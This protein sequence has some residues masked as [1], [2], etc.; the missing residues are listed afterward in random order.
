MRQSSVFREAV[1]QCEEIV[2]TE[3]G[4]PLPITLDG[5]RAGLAAN[6][7]SGRPHGMRA[8]GVRCQYALSEFWRAC[9]IE[10]S[11]VLGY[12]IG[13]IVAASVTGAL[14]LSGGLAPRHC[15]C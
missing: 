15:R 12:G 7:Q 1:Q 8:C 6:Q 11:V 13:E 4:L 10:P 3:L 14:T 5:E 2:R 9:G